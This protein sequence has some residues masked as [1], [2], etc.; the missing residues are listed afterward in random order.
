[1]AILFKI[2][3]YPLIGTFMYLTYKEDSRYENS[4]LIEGVKYKDILASSLKIGIYDKL[5]IDDNSL[6]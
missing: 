2:I 3:K 4:Q 6:I 5:H 1:M